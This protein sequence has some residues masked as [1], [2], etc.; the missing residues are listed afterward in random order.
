MKSSYMPGFKDT[1]FLNILWVKHTEHFIY[2]LPL[3]LKLTYLYLAINHLLKWIL[4]I[5]AN[6]TFYKAAVTKTKII[7][8][9]VFVSYT[10]KKNRF[11][12][13]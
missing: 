12:Q 1:Q 11:L 2:D 5:A 13:L 3:Q 6:L 8:K 7:F 9:D 10:R 4:S